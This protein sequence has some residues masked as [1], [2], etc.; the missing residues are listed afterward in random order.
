[1]ILKN[2]KGQSATEYMLIIAIVVLGLV[3]AASRLIP[4]FQDGVEE[5]S[6][7]VV[8]TLR[9]THDMSKEGN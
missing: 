3:A 5:L 4:K 8:E 6:N 9:T 7:N 2:Q 1:M